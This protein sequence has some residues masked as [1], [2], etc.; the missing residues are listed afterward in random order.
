MRLY[1]HMKLLEWYWV[2]C[3]PL[4]IHVIVLSHVRD[5]FVHC[6]CDFFILVGD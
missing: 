3:K 6:N 1:C 4:Q 2:V 5:Y